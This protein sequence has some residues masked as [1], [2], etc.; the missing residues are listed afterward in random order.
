[1]KKKLTTKQFDRFSDKIFDLTNIAA[2]ALIFSQFLTNEFKW[3]ITI[4]GVA[5]LVMGYWL[6]NR[7]TRNYY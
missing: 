7:F 6:G 4:L 2:G 3:E 5:I 1:M